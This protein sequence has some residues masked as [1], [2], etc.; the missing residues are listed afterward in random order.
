[1]KN[2]KLTVMFLLLTSL[3]TYAQKKEVYANFPEN[4][5]SPD[6]SAKAH[7]K[8]ETIKLKTGEWTL[9]Q[10]LL[11]AVAGRDRFNPAGKQSVRMQQNR[12]KS[13]YLSM[14]FDLNE[15]A[16]KVTLS[17]GSY[18]KD[19]LSIW[20][21]EYSTDGGNVWQAAGKEITTE[22]TDLKTA[23]FPLNLKGKVRFRINKLGLGDGKKDP[24][25]KNGRLSIDDITIYKN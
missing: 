22:T 7:Y 14:D 15:G 1:M 16:S 21:L 9:D 11:A 18:Y 10:A 23:E 12:S 20:Q 24:A 25:I 6:T 2:F 4:F 13:A 5:E 17:Y 8:A 3:A 19:P